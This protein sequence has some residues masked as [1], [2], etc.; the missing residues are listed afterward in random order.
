MGQQAS[1]DKSTEVSSALEKQAKSLAELSNLKN[2]S[3]YI[4]YIL[5]EPTYTL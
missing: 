1:A 3:I 4:Y 5:W 2:R